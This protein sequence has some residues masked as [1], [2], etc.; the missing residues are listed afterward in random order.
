[1][2]IQSPPATPLVAAVVGDPLLSGPGAG[3]F[4]RLPRARA[5]AFAVAGLYRKA[6]AVT[7][8]QATKSRVLDAL[9]SADVVHYAGHALGSVESQ[10][11]RL[12]LAGDVGDPGTALYGR[13]LTGRLSKRVR[14]VLAGCETAMAPVERAAGLASL[15]AAFLRAG[16][17]AV[18]A[19]LWEIDDSV[20]ESFFLNVHRG[21]VAGEN[22]AG[23]V[24]RAQRSC[25]VD[26]AMQAGG[27]N[28]DWNDRVR[29]PVDGSS[30]EEPPQHEPSEVPPKP[31][32]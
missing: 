16:A 6:T 8:D 5:E 31:K 29:N 2:Q 24:A 28:L 13:D 9:K 3:N 22:T 30:R 14:V 19:S 10:G 4:Q 11:P 7:G 32:T 18:V 1:M 20:S 26:S 17:G 12:L 23:A 27:C 25:R 21:L 15:S